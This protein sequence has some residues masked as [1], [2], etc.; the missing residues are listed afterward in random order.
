[1]ANGISAPAAS[2]ALRQVTLVRSDVPGAALVELAKSTPWRLPV[3]GEDDRFLGFVSHRL[4]EGPQWPW[5]RIKITPASD[6][7]AGASLTVL[8]TERLGHALRWMAGR[9]A[10]SLAL[11]DALGRFRGLLSDVDALRAARQREP[12]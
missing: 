8:E 9:G 6:L 10:R 1:M 5:H 4:L 7:V 11:V 2:A 12:L 3:V